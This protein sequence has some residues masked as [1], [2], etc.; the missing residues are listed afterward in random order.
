[1]NGNKNARRDA[2]LDVFKSAGFRCTK[3]KE[4]A[5]EYR[6]STSGTTVYTY[7]K[8]GNGKDIIIAIHPQIDFGPLL[9]LGGVHL[10]ETGNPDGIRFGT[11]MTLFPPKIGALIPK[12]P[13]SKVGRFLGIDLISSDGRPDARNLTTFRTSMGTSTHREMRVLESGR[14]CSANLH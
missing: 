13:K 4:K 1:M 2:Y 8:Q 3:Q 6:H 10:R 5:D 9:K 12:D 7:W 11:A 14:L